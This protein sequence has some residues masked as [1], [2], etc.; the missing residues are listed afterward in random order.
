MS[1]TFVPKPNYSFEITSIKDGFLLLDTS[2][3][4]T[5]DLKETICFRS[6][7]C[8]NSNVILQKTT[9][10]FTRAKSDVDKFWVGWFLTS[11]GESF[12]V[13]EFSFLTFTRAFFA[14]EP[15]ICRSSIENGPYLLRR[16]PHLY[17]A[18]IHIVIK[19]FHQQMCLCFLSL[20]WCLTT[21][22]DW[23]KWFTFLL[24]LILGCNL[25]LNFI[26]LTPNFD[27]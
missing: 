11:F 6:I 19:I 8:A 1:K 22:L 23:L 4:L 9:T 24:F 17:G 14:H 3:C 26:Q 16:V 10:Y 18:N 2:K 25:I 20:C 15:G 13:K 21:L 27:L 12:I 5:F 7:T